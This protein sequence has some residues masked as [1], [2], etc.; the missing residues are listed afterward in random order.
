[1]TET[2]IVAYDTAEHAEQAIE[3]LRLAGVPAGSIHR[4]T[5]DGDD[6]T[7]ERPAIVEMQEPGLWST[8][9]GG[10]A[11]GERLIQDDSAEAGGTVVRVTQIPAAQYD[12]VH[13]ILQRFHPSDVRGRPVA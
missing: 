12:A 4:H 2:I 7:S 3:A 10:D 8:L 1:M 6:L 13:G 9:F 5:R 11:P